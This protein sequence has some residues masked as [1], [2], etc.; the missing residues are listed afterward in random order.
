L[1]ECF[2]DG[3]FVIAKGGWERPTMERGKPMAIE[4]GTILPV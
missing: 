3:D 4:K 1:E 2:V